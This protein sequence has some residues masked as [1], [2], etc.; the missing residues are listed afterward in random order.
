MKIALIRHPHLSARFS[1]PKTRLSALSISLMFR[2]G[3][4]SCQYA[5]G[6]LLSFQNGGFVYKFFGSQF[7]KGEGFVDG[8]YITFL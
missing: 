1:I 2:P 6:F 5:G 3:M 4:I 8:K 7:T